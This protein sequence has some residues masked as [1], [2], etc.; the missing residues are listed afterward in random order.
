MKY[1]MKNPFIP[2]ALLMAAFIFIPSAL[3]APPVF[4]QSSSN[5]VLLVRD[6]LHLPVEFGKAH[7]FEYHIINGQNGITLNSTYNVVCHFHLYNATGHHIIETSDRTFSHGYDLGF[8]V[9]GADLPYVGKYSITAFCFC[10]NCSVDMENYPVIGGIIEEDFFTTR[11]GLSYN[12]N[13]TVYFVVLLAIIALIIIL[14][15]AADKIEFFY[16]S[17]N[18][19]QINIGKYI[20]FLLAGWLCAALMSVAIK[21]NEI[22]TLTLS[23][24]L[25]GVY[26]ALIWIMLT[27]TTLS[28][29]GFIFSIFK[30]IGNYG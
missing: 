29:L 2:F 18:N 9:S 3:S 26:S 1:N 22:Y 8:S 28:L 13:N 15:Y 4:T 10:Y 12:Q 30:R 11:T 23:G 20:I 14:M 19:A 7:E 21:I 16:L 25:E 24:T 27:I 17:E 5:N 6:A